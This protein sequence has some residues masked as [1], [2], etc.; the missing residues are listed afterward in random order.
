MPEKWCLK[1]DEDLFVDYCNKYGVYNYSKKE[2]SNSYAHFPAVCNCTTRTAIKT[3]Y[4]EITF[5][6]FRE[7]VLKETVTKVDLSKQEPM[8]V[9]VHVKTS[10]EFDF[11]ISKIRE[12][13]DRYNSWNVYRTESCIALDDGCYQNKDWFSKNNYRVVSFED[14]C[15]DNGYIFAIQ[16][17]KKYEWKTID[18]AKISIENSFESTNAQENINILPKPK[19]LEIV[20]ISKYFK[21]RN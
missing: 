19:E 16:E 7:Y 4:T 6:Q 1:S 15:K 8:K 20:P 12:K 9:A 11:V 17:S 10:E 21:I 14:W 3:G 13:S 2:L 18:F 5:E